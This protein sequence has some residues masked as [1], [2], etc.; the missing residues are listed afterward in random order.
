MHV[1]VNS[2]YDVALERRGGRYMGKGMKGDKG[3]ETQTLLGSWLRGRRPCWRRD[4]LAWH[5]LDWIR[6]L[7][8]RARHAACNI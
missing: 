3:M 5:V 2:S 6:Q 4:L 1:N 7:G 8:S